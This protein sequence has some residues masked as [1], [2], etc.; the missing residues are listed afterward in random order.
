MTTLTWLLI[1]MTQDFHQNKDARLHGSMGITGDWL[2]NGIMPS[3][4]L[5]R[6]FGSM[7]LSLQQAKGLNEIL[8]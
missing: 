2:I 1:Q 5:G 6:D 4:D 7:N 3:G 8:P